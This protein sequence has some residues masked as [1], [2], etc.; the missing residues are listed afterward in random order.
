MVATM[1]IALAM[2]GLMSIFLVAARQE[3]T[4]TNKGGAAFYQT[5]ILE[6]LK[7]FI[8]EDPAGYSPA[9]DIEH[10]CTS[11]PVLANP[12]Y[13]LEDSNG[14]T[15]GGTV[16]EAVRTDGTDMLPSTDD[17]VS[18]YNATASYTVE[19]QDSGGNGR[20]SKKIT[21]DIDYEVPNL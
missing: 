6:E 14:T 7:H 10:S 1:V 15:A 12:H 3:N 8:V 17:L 13:I 2:A 4:T 19:D 5:R 20:V 9:T 21:V 16:H 18:K 11:I